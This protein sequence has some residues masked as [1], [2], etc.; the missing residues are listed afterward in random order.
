MKADD[1]EALRRPS[2]LLPSRPGGKRRKFI[3]S[4][5]V[6]RPE[7]LKPT[8]RPLASSGFPFSD[9]STHYYYLAR[10]GVFALANAWKL[11]GEE[12]LFPDYFH[13]VEYEALLA[14]GV[15]LSFYPV[16]PRMQ[17]DPADIESR[18]SKKT[19]A[20]YL[21]HYLGFPGPQFR[22]REL[23]DR[24]GIRLIEDCA[25]SLFSQS[26][27]VPLGR[28]GDAAIFCLY[29]TIALPHGGALVI[30]SG[31]G[32]NLPATRAP[33]ITSTLAYTVSSMSR[34]LENTGR[35]R[36]YSVLDDIRKRFKTKLKAAGVVSVAT[37]SFDTRTVD[38]GMSQLSAL[39]IRHQDCHEIIRRRRAN[40][41]RLLARLQHTKQLIFPALPDGVCP[42]F[43]PFLEEKKTTI[44]E[45][46]LASGIEAA[47]FWSVHPTSVPLTDAVR[48]LRSSVVE[49]PCHQDLNEE[50]MDYIADSF[51][52]I[53]ARTSSLAA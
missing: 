31:D 33:S 3:F 2:P 49:L 34:Y 19:R 13:G 50:D 43:F 27:G 39:M 29:K 47:N 4:R 28:L 53:R 1:P 51:L 48:T 14:A 26:Q 17:V 21:I 5:A 20:V 15:R 10:N 22:L 37:N 46:L 16:G 6:L 18:I 9:R 11:S 41:M 36:T 32:H 30:K 52:E 25:L 23:C 45:D 40:Y 35:S 42:L 12:I 44:I 24:L 38:L 7:F 8:D